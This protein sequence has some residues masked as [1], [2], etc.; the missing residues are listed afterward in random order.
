MR[1][2]RKWHC[3][4]LSFGILSIYRIQASH[5]D[6]SLPKGLRLP[7]DIDIE[8]TRLHLILIYEWKKAELPGFF[9]K[10]FLR[11]LVPHAYL[12]N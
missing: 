9:L 11:V 7:K 5:L 4:G 8:L 2:T 3:C 1:K 10:Y 6:M 12:L